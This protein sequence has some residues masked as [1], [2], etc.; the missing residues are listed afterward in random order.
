MRA[1]GLA[2]EHAFAFPITQ[3]EIGDALGL[4]TVHVNRTLK[5]IREAGLA[6]LSDRVLK[7]LDWEGLKEA[8]EFDPTYLH[9]E[10]DQAAA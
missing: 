8:G 1:V 4:T 3:T 6:T 10:T 7:V 2:C 5:T 9:M